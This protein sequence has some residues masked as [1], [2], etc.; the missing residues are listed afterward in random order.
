MS[1]LGFIGL[2]GFLGFVCTLGHIGGILIA[3]VYLQTHL[4]NPLNLISGIRVQAKTREFFQSQV[5]Q[6]TCTDPI[7][8]SFSQQ[9][10]NP[11]N[12]LFI[13]LF[14]FIYHGLNNFNLARYLFNKYLTASEGS[15]A[16]FAHRK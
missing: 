8:V 14:N 6:T 12:P 3:G 16:T 11:F 5:K 15:L 2:D 7:S 10:S 4:R 9:G 1:E 13:A